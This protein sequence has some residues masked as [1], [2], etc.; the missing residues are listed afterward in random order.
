MYRNFKKVLCVLMVFVIAMGTLSV[1]AT[2]P[3]GGMAVTV[4]AEQTAPGSST[5]VVRLYIETD[6]TMYGMWFSIPYQSNHFTFVNGAPNRA[7][8]WG[9]MFPPFSF[10]NEVWQHTEKHNVF[11]PMQDGLFWTGTFAI[12]PSI[13]N[14][15]RIGGFDFFADPCCC[16]GTGFT[17]NRDS[18]YFNLIRN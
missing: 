3:P 5:A 12:D 11:M 17:V 15:T 1:G 4:V 14:G 13:A 7:G 8:N 6:F 2:P 18:A 16:L 10:E 9:H